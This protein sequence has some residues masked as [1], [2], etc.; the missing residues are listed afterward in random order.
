MAVQT[1]LSGVLQVSGY[2]R[3][4]C[5]WNSFVFLLSTRIFFSW[6]RVYNGSAL[7]KIV[8]VQKHSMVCR[9]P[10]R[11]FEELFRLDSEY[12]SRMKIEHFKP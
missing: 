5:K 1:K 12:I 3:N 11:D 10:I 2:D 4:A 8:A 6:N 7:L 9:K